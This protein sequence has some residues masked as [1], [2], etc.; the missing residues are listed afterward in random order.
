MSL[1]DDPDSSDSE[2]QEE[3]SKFAKPVFHPSFRI[4]N[5]FSILEIFIH[6]QMVKQVISST[7]SI[8]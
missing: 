7:C 2:H 3:V 1:L 4:S 5:P 6:K 8:D